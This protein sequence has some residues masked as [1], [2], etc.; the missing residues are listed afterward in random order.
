M[1]SMKVARKTLRGRG[2]GKSV[3]D[4]GGGCHYSLGHY[5]DVI[6]FTSSLRLAEPSSYVNNTTYTGDCCRSDGHVISLHL[7]CKIRFLR[8]AS[9]RG[10]KSLFYG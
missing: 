1:G 6:R 3:A 8:V 9:I 2:L 4:L 7:P 10:Q 5:W